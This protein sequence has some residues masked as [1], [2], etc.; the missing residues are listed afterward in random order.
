MREASAAVPALLLLVLAQGAASAQPGPGHD[1]LDA[2]LGTGREAAPPDLAPS[3]TPDPDAAMA[4]SAFVP[5]EP[6]PPPPTPVAPPRPPVAAPAPPPGRTLE[7]NIV[8]IA[9]G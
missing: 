2:G 5:S 1:D 4:P 6:V 7:F 8:P 9:G 3:G